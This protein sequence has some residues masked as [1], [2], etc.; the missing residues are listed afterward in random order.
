MAKPFGRVL[1]NRISVP[2]TQDEE[3]QFVIEGRVNG[4]MITTLGGAD[5]PPSALQDAKNVQIILDKLR[6]SY[7]STLL[8]PTKPDSDPVLLIY[9][10]KTNAGVAYTLRFTQNEVHLRLGSWTSLT[11]TLTGGLSNRFQAITAFDKCIFTNGI[12]NIKVVDTTSNSYVDL[13]NAPT[14]RYISAFYNRVVGFGFIGGTNNPVQLGWSGD[15]NITEWDPLVDLSAGSTPLIESPGDFSDYGTGVFGFTNVMILLREKSI[16]LATKQPSAS[17]PFNLF[18]AV[19]GKGCTCPYS[20][21]V[22]PG[23]LGWVDART[24]KVY[25]YQPG[26][27]GGEPASI[28]D[29]IKND[30]FRSITEHHDVVGSYSTRHNRY[31]VMLPMIGSNYRKLWTFDFEAKGWTYEEKENITSIND[32]DTLSAPVFIDDLPGFIDDLTGYIDDLGGSVDSASVRVFGFNDGS[33]QYEDEGA[34]TLNGT[35]FTS[36]ITTKDFQ[37]PVVTTS[38]VKAKFEFNIITPVTINLAYSRDLGKTWTIAK[39]VTYPEPG[40]NVFVYQKLI[41]SRKLTYKIYSTNGMWELLDYEIHGVG[42][43][44]V[45]TNI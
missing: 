40:M 10:F 21:A 8:T 1:G 19:A 37:W 4:G 36:S 45:I 23:G 42:S 3:K 38:F 9:S 22:L 13:G 15:G 28:G 27:N 12:D 35:P 43:G 17:N 25:V 5:I 14:Y 44:E 29:A 11:G 6:T 26:P 39:S 18:A 32:I 34:I 33:I 16:W 30:L 2:R 31:T 41:R 24:Q 20:A 7:G